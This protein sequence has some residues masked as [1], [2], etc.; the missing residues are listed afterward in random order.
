MSEQRKADIKRI[1]E[2]AWNKRN[3]EALDEFYAP[4]IVL[5]RPPFSDIEGLEAFKESH[6]SF[7]SAFPDLQMTIEDII[8]EGDRDAL[9]DTMRGTHTG[10]SSTM[11]PPTG[12]QVTTV[13]IAIT[14]WEG[15]KRVDEWQYADQL[16]FLQQLGLTR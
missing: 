10:E 13:G 2:E 8:V 4:N 6:R 3:V 11:G 14:H 9:R 16:G 5:R 12:K 1:I 7:L 15:G